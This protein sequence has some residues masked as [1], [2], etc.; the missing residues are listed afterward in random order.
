MN[1]ITTSI[2]LLTAVLA[3]CSAYA[4]SPIAI[5]YGIASETKDITFTVANPSDVARNEMVYIAEAPATPFRLLD[6]RGHEVPYQITH[7]GKLIFRVSIPAS[8]D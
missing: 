4:A 7:D 3:S 1:N 6:A 8:T 2:L 5:G